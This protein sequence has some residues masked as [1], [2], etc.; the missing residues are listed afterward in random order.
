MKSWLKLFRLKAFR[1][2]RATDTFSADL[3]LSCTHRETFI[4]PRH[5]KRHTVFISSLG[6]IHDLFMKSD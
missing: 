3:L 6:N 1:A 5:N 4:A 2:L